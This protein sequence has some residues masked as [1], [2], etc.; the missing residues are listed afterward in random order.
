M[1]RLR[2]GAEARNGR[3]ESWD[4]L[5]EVSLSWKSRPPGNWWAQPDWW[6][7]A[8]GQ[9]WAPM[10][11]KAWKGGALAL[12]QKCDSAALASATL[13]CNPCHGRQRL[14]IRTP[15]AW[16]SCPQV[17][18]SQCHFSKFGGLLCGCHCTLDK[19]LYP[20]GSNMGSLLGL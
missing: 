7:Q 4:C 12:T 16:M 11:G 5:A 6:V 13:S 17:T 9:A 2:P 1:P 14:S 18:S 10:C 15:L 3:Q 20:K 19:C 8:L